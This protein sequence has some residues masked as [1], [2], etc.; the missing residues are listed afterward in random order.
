MIWHLYLFYTS[1]SLKLKDKESSVI[2]IKI[3][4]TLLQKINLIL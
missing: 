1:L 4:I 3:L 2:L